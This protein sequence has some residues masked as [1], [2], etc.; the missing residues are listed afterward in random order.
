MCALRAHIK[1]SIFRNIFLVIEKAIN[2]FSILEKIFLNMINYS[3]PLGHTLIKTLKKILNNWQ[4]LT[5]D[6]MLYFSFKKLQKVIKMYKKKKSI[7]AV[8]S[9]KRR[10]KKTE[11][12]LCC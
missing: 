11:K 9:Y 6:V 5:T 12:K 4:M 10:Q 1:P 7:K 2:T 3:V 8:K